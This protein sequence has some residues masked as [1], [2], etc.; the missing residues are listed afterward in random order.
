MEL[1][2]HLERG[3]AMKRVRKL[4]ASVV[5]AGRPC[6]VT[7]HVMRRMRNSV[8]GIP[9]ILWTLTAGVGSGTSR[10]VSR[11]NYTAMVAREV[12]RLLFGTHS[13]YDEVS[14]RFR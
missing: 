11:T 9:T 3:G 13:L 7:Y 12:R 6:H 1:G 14:P 8:P 2:L 10:G 4:G 5:R